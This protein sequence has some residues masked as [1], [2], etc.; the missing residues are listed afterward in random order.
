M[1]IIQFIVLTLIVT[2]YAIIIGGLVAR[3]VKRGAQ[4]IKEQSAPEPE[5]ILIRG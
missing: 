2:V 3:M 1:G 5:E 4:E